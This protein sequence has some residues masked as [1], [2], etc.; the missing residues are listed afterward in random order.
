M[1]YF[2]SVLVVTFFFTTSSFS[3]KIIKVK[4]NMPS[5]LVQGE[6]REIKVTIFNTDTTEHTGTITLELIDATTKK[7]VDGW[8]VNIFPFQ[9]FTAEKKDSCIIKFPI[10]VP[11]IFK[12][13]LKYRLVASSKI[14]KNEDDLIG[15]VTDE[16]ENTIPIVTK[17][18]PASRKAGIK[19]R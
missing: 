14:I 15:I 12:N 6:K 2:F 8:F 4:S 17:K 11:V 5:H 7:S 9:Y 10:Q 16:V 1:Q 18:I 13:R 19:K 3:Q